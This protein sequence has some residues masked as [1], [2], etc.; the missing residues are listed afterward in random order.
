GFEVHMGYATARHRAAI[1]T[2]G[3]VP[4]LHRISFAPFR[5]SGEEPVAVE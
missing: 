1:D 3:P 4:R 2:H 5:L